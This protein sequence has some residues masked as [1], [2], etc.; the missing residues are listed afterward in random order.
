MAGASIVM[1]FPNDFTV[2]CRSEGTEGVIE[3]L[4]EIGANP[5]DKADGGSSALD[6]ALWHV[7]FARLSAFGSKRPNSK[8]DVSDALDCVRELLARGAVWNAGDT[9]QVTSLRRTLLDCEPN[10]NC[11][12]VSNGSNN[13]NGGRSVTPSADE[14]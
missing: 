7:S 4:L 5:N 6:N 1:L 11:E 13:W 2:N 9:Y 14:T 8:Y 10:V 3:Y 12:C